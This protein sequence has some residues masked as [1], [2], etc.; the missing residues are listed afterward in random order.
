MSFRNGTG[1]GLGQSSA[2]LRAL[3]RDTE[4]C[5]SLC[6]RVA[7][8]GPVVSRSGP[9]PVRWLTWGVGR[10]EGHPWGRTG[11]ERAGCESPSSP[12]KETGNVGESPSPE[13]LK[14][15]SVCPPD[16]GGVRVSSQSPGPCFR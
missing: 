7:L 6:V 4:V 15:T 2:T 14:G 16:T 10:P 5:L 1:K 12:T 13:S 9:W 8:G 3:H 11:S